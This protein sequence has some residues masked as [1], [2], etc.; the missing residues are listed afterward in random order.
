[1]ANRGYSEN[2]GRFDMSGG[3]H[4]TEDCKRYVPGLV[5]QIAGPTTVGEQVDNGGF[6]RTERPVGDEP[7]VLPK[8]KYSG[9]SAGAPGTHRVNAAYPGTKP[10]P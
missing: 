7:A 5:E 4:D 10:G 1:M 8:A 6:V 3:A 9:G 2:D